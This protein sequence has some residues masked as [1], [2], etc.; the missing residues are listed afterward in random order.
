[1]PTPQ[2]LIALADV[3]RNAKWISILILDQPP[4][5]HQV[6][7]TLTNATYLEDIQFESQLHT[8]VL[9]EFTQVNPKM[10]GW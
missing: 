3:L 10:M 2:H 1:V 4:L 7:R 5:K 8:D 6:G 9:R